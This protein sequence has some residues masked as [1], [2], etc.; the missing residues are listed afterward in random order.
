MSYPLPDH[1]WIE[2]EART[3]GRCH[4]IHRN[5]M[6]RQIEAG[7]WGEKIPYNFRGR[8]RTERLQFSLL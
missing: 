6:H 7:A 3:S 4:A 5:Y 1:D 8:M 2:A